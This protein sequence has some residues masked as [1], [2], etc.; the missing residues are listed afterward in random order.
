VKILTLNTWTTRG[1]WQE[2]WEVIYEGLDVLQPD[3]ITFQ[4]VFRRDLAQ[5]V[6]KRVGFEYSV[7]GPEASGLAILSRFP[8]KAEAS[9]IMQTQS[10][11]EEYTR[12]VIFAELEVEKKRL[13][14][15]NT[16]LSW[17]LDEGEIREKQVEE[18]LAFATE[19]AGSKETLAMGDFNAPPSTPEIQKMV[20]E[21]KVSDT[22]A[23]L[24]PHDPGLTWDNRNP[25]CADHGLPD[26][27][28]DYIFVRNAAKLLKGPQSIELAFTKPNAQGML[29]SDHYGV[30]ATFA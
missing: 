25:F 21:G 8:V 24:H 26:R 16:H 2:R 27:R 30:F 12:F 14:V 1:P 17:K 5:E 11:T 23:A 4:E 22:Y 18:L 13:A 28:L 20:R 6:M 15:L 3:L 10:P 7:F 19:K 29:A 9:H